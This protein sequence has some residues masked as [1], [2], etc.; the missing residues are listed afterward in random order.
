MELRRFLARTAQ[1]YDI[2]FA[3]GSDIDSVEAEIKDFVTIQMGP[4]DVV[5]KARQ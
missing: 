1:R 5:I 2:E 4:L 3:P